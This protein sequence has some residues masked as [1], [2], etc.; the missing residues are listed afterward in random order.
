MRTEAGEQ[1]TRCPESRSA[2]GIRR[3]PARSETCCA[4]SWRVRGRAS[5]ASLS[6]GG[7]ATSG[8]YPR[9]VRLVRGPSRAWPRRWHVR[10]LSPV[11]PC[12]LVR[13]AVLDDPVRG[14]GCGV[15]VAEVGVD[16]GGAF[17]LHGDAAAL[18]HPRVGVDAMRGC[19]WSTRCGGR[20]GVSPL[21]ARACGRGAEVLP[22]GAGV[23][24]HGRGSLPSATSSD[25]MCAASRVPPPLAHSRWCPPIPG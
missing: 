2:N 15:L 24:R 8:V 13:D 21:G 14:R 17:R 7:V 9:R 25:A 1:L 12:L 18:E 16:V 6:G 11:L 20:M 10:R 4:E 19:R 23:D 3:P 22:P 5:W